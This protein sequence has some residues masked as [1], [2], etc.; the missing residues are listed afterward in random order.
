MEN[1]GSLLLLVVDTDLYRKSCCKENPGAR[2]VLRMKQCS[3]DKKPSPIQRQQ[4][5]CQ[6]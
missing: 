6:P 2:D 5:R 1:T 4:L 3:E